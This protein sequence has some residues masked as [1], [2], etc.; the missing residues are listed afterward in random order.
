MTTSEIGQRSPDYIIVCVYNTYKQP[1]T[2]MRI[3]IYNIEGTIQFWIHTFIFYPEV[4]AGFVIIYDNV[5]Q[6]KC[7]YIRSTV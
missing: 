6:M 4:W 1:S 2:T 7:L 3:I 5:Q